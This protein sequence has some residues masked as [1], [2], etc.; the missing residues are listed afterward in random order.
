MQQSP[1]IKHSIEIEQFLMEGAYNKVLAARAQAPDPLY[2]HYMELLMATVRD[3]IGSCSEKAYVTLSMGEAQKLLKLES[4]Q[5]TAAFVEQR[6]WAVA[7]GVIRFKS[8]E[9]APPS[10][11]DIP[12]AALM[13]QTLAYAREL[14]RIV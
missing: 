2:A 7:D 1:H 4:A 12:A 13:A 14:E 6:G 10:A 9:K 5:Q 11:Q 3:E 8:G